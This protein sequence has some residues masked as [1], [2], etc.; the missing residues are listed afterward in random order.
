MSRLPAPMGL[1]IDRNQPLHF[2][3]DGKAYQGFA[4]DSIASALLANGRFLL[5]RSFKYHRPRGPLTMA[6][7][8]ANTLVQLPNEPNVLADTHLLE[9]GVQ[10]TGQNFNGTLD[11]DKDAYL[12]KFSKFMPV[13]FYYRSFYKPKGAW[14]LWEPI[15]RKKAG[16]GVLDL[17]FQP[18]YF[19]K[20]YLFADLAV[21]GAGPAGLQAA[22]TAANA[23]AKVLLIEQQP[24]LGGSLTYAR[25]DVENNRADTLR[26]ELINAVEGHAN[27]QVLKKATCNA[28]FTDNYLPVIQ[29]KRMYKVRATQCLIASGSFDQ[30][31]I[32]RNNDL[33]GVM[34]S[35]AAQ[36]LMKLY[37]V[38]PGKRAV[39]LTGNDDGYY[40]A[41]DLHEQ[42]VQ[43]AA[44][45]DMR[46]NPADRALLI[47]LEQRGITCHLSSTVFEALHEKGMR[48]VSGVDIRKITGHGQVAN[49]SFHLDCDLLCMS[50]GYMPVYQLLCQAGG[51]LSY[52]DQLAEFTLSGLPKNL[53]VAGSAHG[54]H[55]LDNV[56]ADATR[57]AHEIISSLG[58]VIDVKPLPLR[59]EAQVNFPWPIF[60]HPK[61]K[62]FVDFDEDLQVRDI[63]NATKI[64]YRDVQLVKRFSTVG[65]GPSQGRHSALPTARLVAASTQRSVSETG[66]TTARPPFEAEKLAHVAGRAF[67]PYRQTPMHRRHLEA[68]AKMMPAG[69]WQRPAYYGKP[70][71]RD[72]CMQAEA[73]HVRRKVG[74][75]D[76]STLGG[77]D[78]RGPDAAEFLNRMYTFAFL[79][80]PV[81]RSRYALMTNEHGVVIDD[82]VCAR[83]AEN[84][85]YVTAT[86]S[87]VDRIYQQILKWNAQWRLNVDIANVTAAISAVNVAGPDSRKVLEKVCSDLDLSAEGFPYLGVRL[88]TVAG[89]KARLLRV[90]FVGEL[91]YEI[92]V[93]ARHALKLWDALI[94]AGKDFDIRPFGVETQRLL[95]LEK[96]HVIISQDTDGMTHPSEIDMGWAVSRTK[97]F[98]V[99]RRSV[100][101]LEAQ[102]QKR[103]LVG[104]T[105]PKKSPQPLEGHLVL[106]GADISG[107]VT[108]CEYS[109]S[110]DQIIGLAYA[111]FDQ[112]TPGQQIPIRVEDGVVV[113]ATVVKL[114]FFD[115]DNQRQEL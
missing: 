70:N 52:D 33:P 42:G 49:S 12:G 79:K 43:V 20:A 39:V 61:G 65:M 92:H 113:Q 6:G 21:V 37:A 16:L 91:G 50:G 31:V 100:D 71:E 82:G 103:K 88:G 84:H 74:I 40:A 63:I 34:L 69:I 80:Q 89:I 7:Q 9:N 14:K 57:T 23:G 98:F 60:P 109:Q 10:V 11:N 38:K 4:G 112:S 62:D 53:S 35:S 56:L 77:L 107:N 104:F 101:I 41:L 46:T 44:L 19:D 32:F 29:G 64:G 114:P 108:S 115:P 17:K 78:V 27:I 99:G 58:L 75:I 93:P 66:V 110:L 67:D 68:G 47:A 97:S 45:V 54:F 72:K 15:I 55:A 36:R 87:G 24:I 111:A 102:P 106:K 105:L 59:P 22:L 51:K 73:L 48:H 26:R 28:W 83:F 13:G 76:V 2:S 25:F 96:G 86:T 94:E 85:F 30:P 90:G 95:R 18:E 1:L 8:D 81:G 5:S 3:F